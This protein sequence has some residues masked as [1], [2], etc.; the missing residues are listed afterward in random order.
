[1]SLLADYRRLK[2]YTGA[3]LLELQQTVLANY[4]QFSTKLKEGTSHYQFL[5]EQEV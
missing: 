5:I 4:Q 1:L 3:E 2:E